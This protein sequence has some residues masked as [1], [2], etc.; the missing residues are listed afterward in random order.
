MDIPK[1]YLPAGADRVY[2][3]NRK[4]EFLSYLRQIRDSATPEHLRLVR[5]VYGD[6]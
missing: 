4:A 3:L 1:P 5:E 2:S 6:R